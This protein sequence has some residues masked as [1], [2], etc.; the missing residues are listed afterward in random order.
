[1]NRCLLEQTA[2]TLAL[3]VCLV[4][5][6][7][8]PIVPQRTKNGGAAHWAVALSAQRA[9]D[10]A[11][12]AQLCDILGVGVGIDGWLPDR[13]GKWQLTYWSAAKTAVYQVAVDSDGNVHAQEWKDTGHRGH[14]L[15]AVWADSPKVWAATRSHQKG[16]SLSTFDAELALDVDPEHFPGQ[17][18]WRIRFY[19]QDNSRETHVV[20]PEGKWLLSY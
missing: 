18:V 13:G 15:P 4:A 8:A 19:M 10:W 6:C 2:M 1:V 11:R 16:E 12:D 7:A 3:A 20:S 17:A 5:A 9:S 14:S